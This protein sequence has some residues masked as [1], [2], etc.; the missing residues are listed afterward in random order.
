MKSIAFA[1][2][3]VAVLSPSKV[4][5]WN[6]H[7]KYQSSPSYMIRTGRSITALGVGAAIP[8][9]VSFTPENDDSG[10]DTTQ[11]PCW[12]DIW[13]YDC[14]MSTVYSAAFI[15]KDWIKS[16]PCAAGIAVSSKRNTRTPRVVCV[17]NPDMSM[18][19]LLLFLNHDRSTS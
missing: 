10:D 16:M 8:N 13:N 1:F 11:N 19:L 18:L 2:V 12:Q 6:F 15:A 14:A 7:A 17:L 9:D 5:S 4:E 3:A